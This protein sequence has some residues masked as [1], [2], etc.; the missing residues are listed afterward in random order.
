[1]SSM[2]L[3]RHRPAS[4]AEGD[5]GDDLSPSS[6]HAMREDL[7]LGSGGDRPAGSG[8][9]APEAG[10]VIPRYGEEE[11]DEIFRADA[12]RL[13]YLEPGGKGLY[14]YYTDYGLVQPQR[15]AKIIQRRELTG[16]DL[17]RIVDGPDA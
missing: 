10:A 7:P 5:R 13:G 3:N 8:A 4:I 9:P 12:E 1:M 14:Q 15:Y 11:A 2:L 6:L 17:E 16:L